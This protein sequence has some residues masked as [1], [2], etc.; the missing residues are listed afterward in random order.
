[1]KKK[2]YLYIALSV[3]A[4]LVLYSCVKDYLD[5]PDSKGKYSNIDLTVQEAREFF[6]GFVTEFK[7]AG[8]SQVEEQMTRSGKSMPAIAPVW[9]K[10]RTFSLDGVPTVEIPLSTP[11]I[12]VQTKKE[13]QT[14]T[15][16]KNTI[17]YLLAQ[18]TSE[19][20]ILYYEVAYT[21]N[22]KWFKGHNLNNLRKLSLLDM[23]EFSGKITYYDTGGRLIGGRLLKDGRDVGEIKS[24][25]VDASVHLPG[26]PM[27]TRAIVNEEVCID[28]TDEVE[29][30]LGPMTMS[31]GDGEDDWGDDGDGEE[32]CDTITVVVGQ[33]CE[34]VTYDDTFQEIDSNGEVVFK[35]Q[36]KQLTSAAITAAAIHAVAQVI[37]DHGYVGAYCNQGVIDAFNYAYPLELFPYMSANDLVKYWG[38]H[39]NEWHPVSMSQA[40][41]LANQGYFVVGGWIDTTVG[42]HGHVVL[43]VPGE[44]TQHPWNNGTTTTQTYVPNTMDTGGGGRRESSEPITSGFGSD[45]QADV[46][47]YQ[48]K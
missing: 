21:A 37:A 29:I 42:G 44:P 13:G 40:Q 10:G 24:S 33:D 47:F 27:Q 11:L 14:T 20:E 4:A 30:C 34:W 36:S 32:Y 5:E 35:N 3:V 15:H 1:M 43:I 17:Y 31:F 7:V 26:K 2:Y 25:N 12:S 45:K 6:E 38:N 8:F 28:I 19:G 39:P 9:S 16:F 48:Y 18:K 22:V 41:G 23:S 46:K